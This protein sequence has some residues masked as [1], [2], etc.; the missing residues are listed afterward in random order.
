MHFLMIELFLDQ[1]SP[2]P[3]FLLLMLFVFLVEIYAEELSLFEDNSIDYEIISKK[4]NR[5]VL[6]VSSKHFNFIS[7][8]SDRLELQILENNYY[9]KS[10]VGIDE[11]I[12][13]ELERRPKE[14]TEKKE[15]KKYEENTEEEIQEETES[16]KGNCIFF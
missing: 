14:L 13:V 8:Y 6:V 5:I 1:L 16:E 15:K 11:E 12:F 4:K 2:F 9:N 7:D 3:F 10:T